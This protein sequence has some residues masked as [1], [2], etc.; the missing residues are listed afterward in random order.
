[1]HRSEAA[2]GMRVVITHDSHGERLDPIH[3]AHSIAALGWRGYGSRG[4]IRHL[5]PGASNVVRVYFDEDREERTCY[6]DR[7]SNAE[8]HLGPLGLLEKAQICRG[9]VAL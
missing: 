9:A 3:P 6:L 2:V 5:T 7:I 4:V 1:M 8:G